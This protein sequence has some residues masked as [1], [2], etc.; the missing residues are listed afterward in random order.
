M[1]TFQ[2]Y[3]HIRKIGLKALFSHRVIL[4]FFGRIFFFVIVV[5]HRLDHT[6][7]FS[8]ALLE[9]KGGNTFLNLARTVMVGVFFVCLFFILALITLIH[10]QSGVIKT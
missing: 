2:G 9:T 1:T 7:L 8:V 4:G 3:K 5:A 10:F 6:Q